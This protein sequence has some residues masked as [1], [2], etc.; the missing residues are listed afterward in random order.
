MLDV[1]FRYDPLHP[2]PPVQ[3][4][5]AAEAIQVL[6]EGNRL[7]A[8]LL[9]HAESEER[10]EL[11][12]PFDISAIGGTPEGGIP[13]QAPFAAVL[14]CA[15]ARAPVE[16]VFDQNCNALFV[17]R[18]A[19]NVLGSEC[20]GSL[21]Y[22]VSHFP[23]TLKVVAALG[24]TGCGAVS[25][26]VDAFLKPASYL[27]VST[28]QALRLIL[29]RLMIAVRTGALALDQTWQPDASLPGYRAALVEVAVT[30][31]A[32]LCAYTL[33]QHFGGAQGPH[34]VFGIYDLATRRVGVALDPEAAEGR[35]RTPPSDDREF[36]SLARRVAG[37][38]RVKR[39]LGR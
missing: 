15:D 11:V 4:A 30:L 6:E 25:A 36:A 31:N 28:R 16:L 5:T 29:D 35:L 10:E 1:I 21:D 22:A 8:S 39:L 13:K 2:K 23:K 37:S 7:F 20:E 12:L 33:H 34:T 19:G 17:V 38:P 24:H 26:A 18:V 3:P 9:G 32:A 14:G 27:E